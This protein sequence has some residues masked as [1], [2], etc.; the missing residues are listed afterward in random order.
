VI[1][2]RGRRVVAMPLKATQGIQY[3]DAVLAMGVAPGIGVGS[4]MEGRIVD[5]LG[6]PLDGLPAARVAEVWPL[7][8]GVPQPMEREAIREPLQT[9]L[10]VLDGM[11]TVGR[12]QRMGIFGGSGVGKST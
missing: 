5:A 8:G 10:R 11:L 9:G 12:G 1:G 2:F 6:L 7:D 3:G 4:E